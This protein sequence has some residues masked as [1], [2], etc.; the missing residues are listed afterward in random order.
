VEVER[1]DVEV[2]V[3]DMTPKVR[4][5]GEFIDYEELSNRD[6]DK[7][8]RL[9]VRAVEKAGGAVN[10]SAVYPASDELYRFVIMLKRKS[11]LE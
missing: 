8:F 11:L 2:V 5:C 10:I 7:L 6:A 4:V 9:A 1:E 3:W